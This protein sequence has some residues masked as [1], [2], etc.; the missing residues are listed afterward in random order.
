MYHQLNILLHFLS[1]SPN[2]TVYNLTEIRHEGSK[3]AGDRL[4]FT[5]EAMLPKKLKSLLPFIRIKWVGPPGVAMTINN[6][7][8]VG[9]VTYSE[10]GL[11]RTLTFDPLKTDHSGLYRCVLSITKEEL[12]QFFEREIRH[13]CAVISE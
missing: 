4:V 9:G 12:A 8:D 10:C 13:D 6:M 1:L 11:S 7:I 5:C 2:Y 3:F